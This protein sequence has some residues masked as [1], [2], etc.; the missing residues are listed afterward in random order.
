[1]KLFD[2]K[3]S[4]A[5]G[6]L[7]PAL[8]GR[9]DLAQYAV[10]AR[11]IENFIV[12]PQGGLVNRP[13]TTV[14]NTGNA[15]LRYSS[16]VKLVPF[17]FSEDDSRVLVFGDGFVD[18]YA[19]SG[20]RWR[21]AQSP[22]TTYHL[23]KLRW[24]QS[25][26][27][28][29]LFHPEVPVHTLSRYGENDWRFQEVEFKLG[30]FRDINTDD[31]HLMRLRKGGDGKYYL[32]SVSPQ[33]APVPYFVS[34]MV[35]SLFKFEQDIK[36]DSD[37]FVLQ[38]VGEPVTLYN[39]FG[40]YTWRTTGKWAGTILVEKCD[41][42]KWAG[43]EEA[44]WE[45]SSFKTY[46]SRPEGAEENFSFSG[47]VE[48]YA[49]HFRFTLQEATYGGRPRIAWSYEG[50]LIERILR[51]TA[52]V[53]DSRVVV[54]PADKLDGEVAPTDAWAIGAFGPLF[55]YPALGIF[56]Q[57]RLVLARTASDIQTVWMSRPANWHSF[58]TSIPAKD[59][60]ALSFTLAS[61][62]VNE[63]RGLTSRGELLILT[64]GGEW[65][66]KA[67]A[68]SD[69]FTPSSLVIVPSG[70][71][72]SHTVP[73]LDVGNAS[74]FVQRHGTAVRSLGYSLEADNYTSSDLS[75]LSAHLFERNPVVAWD[76]QQTPWSVVW[77]VLAGGHVAALT[78]QHEHQVTAWT[79][80][81]FSHDAVVMDVCCVPGSTQD[82]VYFAIQRE[83]VWNIERLNRRN[84]HGDES[85][86]MDAGLYPV[87]S[88]LEC[89]EWEV[90]VNGT[91]QGWHK[92]IPVVTF[93]LFETWGLKAG[94]S[95]ENLSARMDELQFPDKLSPGPA[96]RLYTGDVRMHIPGGTA[97]G[98]R[99]Q[100]IASQARPVTILGL[101]PEV[102]IHEG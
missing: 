49:T 25:A 70:Y 55:G 91:L 16:R 47:A 32:E 90:P 73:P 34:E 43:K 102:E 64:S 10:G 59:D 36:A 28:L 75:I 63:I 22:Y 77:V 6:E 46:V 95:T 9:V 33:N 19:S 60:D 24:L 48:E 56:H 98:C 93:R 40:A 82:D 30:P 7:A 80:H 86:F 14:L 26:D 8:A 85:V 94:I 4:F 44:E 18:V 68:K 17:V 21:V 53:S 39:F 51:I 58:K 76:Y 52:F 1:M 99:V 66:A 71:R 62:Q 92:H 100:V 61:K 50:G 83:G 57:E 5:A 31:Q 35:G 29:Y 3:P 37:E 78:L 97:R 65:T 67:G 74:L 20:Y 89:L 42:A 45:W 96:G 88:T 13:G 2:T 15:A 54:E 23:R 81:E 87:V 12:L 41:L 11:T 72:G 79:R 101:F 38:N 69:V 27:V 84:V